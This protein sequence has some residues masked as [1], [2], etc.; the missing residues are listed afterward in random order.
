MQTP[1]E[2]GDIVIKNVNDVPVRIRD[3]G[4]RDAV[5]RAGLYGG[6]RERQTRRADQRQPAAGQQHGRRWRTKCIRRSKACVRRF[7]PACELSVFYDQ[8]NIV[9]ESIGSVRDA[10]IIGLLLP[11][12]IIWLFLQGSGHGAA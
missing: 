12:F 4:D 5:D 10:I 1:E 2:I 3:I 11:G 9:R 6:D 7:P 8:S